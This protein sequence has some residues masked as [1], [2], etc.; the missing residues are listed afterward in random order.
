MSER[1]TVGDILEDDD[2][3]EYVVVGDESEDRVASISTTLSVDALY[4]RTGQVAT[5]E[6]VEQW[7][8]WRE[9]GLTY[10]RI[11][12]LAG[13]SYTTVSEWCR[14]VRTFVVVVEK[15]E[16]RVRCDRI[17][18]ASKHMP[19]CEVCGIILE[20]SG[21]IGHADDRPTARI[22]W[23]CREQNQEEETWVTG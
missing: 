19:R 14:G 6:R 1:W 20:R 16:A 18:R 13:T 15:E 5:P 7:R 11:A 8:E 4:I 2:G 22:C 17:A 9:Q 21:C 10:D 12:E 3:F 23:A